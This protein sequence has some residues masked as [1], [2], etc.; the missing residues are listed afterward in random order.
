[1]NRKTLFRV[2]LVAFVVA[3]AITVRALGLEQYLSLAYLK[4]SQ[5]RFAALYAERGAVVLGVYMAVYVFVTALSI[6]GAVPLTL[7]GGALFGLTA[8]TVAVSFASTIGA[9]LACA[10]S[11]FVLRDWVQSRFGDRLA[12][13]NEGM[14]REGA[15]YLFSVRLVPVFPFFVVN[16][17]MGLT[18]LPLLTYAWVSQIGMLPATV[19]F[20]NAG[21]ELARIDSLSGIM[22][23]RL[24]F[25]FA[26]LGLFPLVV[27]KTVD[28][29]R[30][31]RGAGEGQ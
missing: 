22:S 15:F 30:R 10:V 5:A 3:L 24:L 23:P 19:V 7:A 9:T 16:L 8:G 2:C 4:E 25:S 1:M 29:L 26:L 28:R 14:A 18:R 20:V 27:R 11:R 31:R 17:V 21:R 6:P 13:V 12:A